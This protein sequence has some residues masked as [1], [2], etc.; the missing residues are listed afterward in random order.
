MGR[1]AS[2]LFSCPLPPCRLGL[3]YIPRPAKLLF[4]HDDGWS[5]Y[6][7]KHGHTLSDWTK[8]AVERMLACGT[9]AM[10]VR[11]DCCTSLNCTHTRFFCQI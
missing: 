2:T 7:D 3:M 10:G 4:Q 11:R 8:L 5:R 9:C 1:L 6:L